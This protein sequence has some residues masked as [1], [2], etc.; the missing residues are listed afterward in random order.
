MQTLSGLKNGFRL[1][2]LLLPPKTSL[3]LGELVEESVWVH[4][5]EIEFLGQSLSRVAGVSAGFLKLVDQSAP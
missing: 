5:V 1:Q 3:A 4:M 2:F